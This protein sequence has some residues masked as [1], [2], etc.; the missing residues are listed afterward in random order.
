VLYQEGCFVHSSAE[1]TDYLVVINRL[2]MTEAKITRNE[3]SSEEGKQSLK[4]LQDAL[5]HT[6]FSEMENGDR[7]YDNTALDKY[8]LPLLQ[9]LGL[10]ASRTVTIKLSC[11]D[12]VAASWLY[13]HANTE[14]NR[15]QEQNRS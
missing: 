10:E 5:S 6:D 14:S 9:S 8:V 3:I 1:T 15:Y 11:T 2:T 13:R 4:E 12:K 7:K